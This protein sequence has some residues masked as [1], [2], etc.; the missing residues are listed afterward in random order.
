MFVNKNIVFLRFAFNNKYKVSTEYE[1]IP[2]KFINDYITLTK[3]TKRYLNI[4]ITNI[5]IK[6]LAYLFRITH[7]RIFY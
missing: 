4:L 7:T 1:I 6:K 3:N 2:C 5:Q